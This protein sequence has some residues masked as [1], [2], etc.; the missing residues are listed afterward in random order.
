MTSKPHI[1]D[2]LRSLRARVFFAILIVGMI[3]VIV[4]VGWLVLYEAANK[5]VPA[6][7]SYQSDEHG[8]AQ[9][10]RLLPRV[11]AAQPVATWLVQRAV[12][13]MRGDEDVQ[14][15]EQHGGRSARA[16]ARC[17]AGPGGGRRFVRA[18]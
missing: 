17:V 9:P 10:E 2:S 18:A 1:P 6:E 11:D 8:S 7:D 16:L 14:V 5:A 3:P 13:A 15:G 4:A 12:G